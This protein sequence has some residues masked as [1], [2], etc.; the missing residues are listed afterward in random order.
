MQREREVWHARLGEQ[1][2]CLG[3]RGG[4]VLGEAGELHQLG[5]GRRQ[6]GARPQHAADRAQGG[7]AREALAAAPAVDRHQERLAHPHVVERLLGDVEDHQQI[8]R[9]ARFLDAD[10]VAHRLHQTVA[11]GGRDAAELGE[12][13][14]T[15]D[16]VEHRGRL[17]REHAPEAVEMGQSGLEVVVVPLAGDMAAFDMLDE[18]EGAGAVDLGLR[19]VRVGGEVFGRVDAVPGRREVLEHR[20]IDRLH[21]EHDGV[22]VGRLDR[23]DVREGGLARGH[24]ACWRIAQAVIGC[25][26]VRGGERR[27]VVEFHAW[28][29]LEGIGH[30]VGRDGP[31]VG[32]VAFEL[33]EFREIEAQQRRIERRRE[34]QGRVGIAAMAVIVRGLRA[35]RELE[36]SAA[37][38]LLSVGG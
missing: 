4:D 24:D 38:G 36:R 27:A 22:G 18:D 21:L 15:L 1:L 28:M 12:Q 6:R 8:E 5:F 17:Q 14:P 13:L 7:D 25:L 35:D 34:M 37:L 19:C 10:L 30:Q 16:G 29:Q 32:E 11:L 31:R 20:G 23:P 26:H 2:L 9:P 33:G 3:T